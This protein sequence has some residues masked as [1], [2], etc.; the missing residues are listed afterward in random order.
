MS[1]T[2]GSF[3]GF[4]PAAPRSAKDKARERAKSKA[5]E[6]P[7]ILPATPDYD[8][9]TTPK[10]RDEESKPPGSVHESVVPYISAHPGEEN[11]TM[12]GDLLNGVGSASSH[13]S[14][15]SSVFSGPQ[16]RSVH[17][18]S[19]G[20]ALST[21]TP[22]TNTDTSPAERPASPLQPTTSFGL[23]PPAGK[24]SSGVSSPPR[25][26]ESMVTPSHLVPRVQ[27][28]DPNKGIKGEKCIYDPQLDPT[29]SSS[30]RK[31]RKA[32]YRAF[33]LVC[34]HNLRGAS[35]YFWCQ[36]G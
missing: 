30:T 32:E 25:A 13:A 36:F 21:L 16:T 33:G 19:D 24:Q 12:Q 23:S 34:T 1:K 28:R 11:D 35:S 8:T 18:A 5:V 3:A 2:G 9:A 6:S 31:K 4:F 15:A 26:S 17:V 29:L 20:T 7:V 10:S 14:T 22:L 27:M